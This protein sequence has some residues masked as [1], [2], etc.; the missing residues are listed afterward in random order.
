MITTHELRK[1]REQITSG[2]ENQ[3]NY[4]VVTKNDLERIRNS[5]VVKDKTKLEQE[6]QVAQEQ[7]TKQMA[8]ALARKNRMMKQDRERAANAPLE[9]KTHK[10]GENT[11]LSKAQD[12]MDEEY[13]DVKHINQMVAS[14]KI[15]TIRDK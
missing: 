11:L 1:L 6:A 5:A 4:S 15:F 9:V 13:D 3:T 14:S 8:V 10:Y 12:Q 7:K 2:K